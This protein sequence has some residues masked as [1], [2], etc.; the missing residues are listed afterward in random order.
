[1]KKLTWWMRL[2]EVL[3]LVRA[4]DAARRLLLHFTHFNESIW[5]IY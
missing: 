4:V 1:M 2:A 3:A 5:V